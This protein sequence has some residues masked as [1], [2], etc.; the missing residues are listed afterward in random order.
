MYAALAQNKCLLVKTSTD[1][2]D[3]LIYEVNT[4]SPLQQSN[5]NRRYKNSGQKAKAR[6]GSLTNGKFSKP[7]RFVF[8]QFRPV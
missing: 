5:I 1:I 6:Q 2:I 8:R 3:I 7:R 4:Q